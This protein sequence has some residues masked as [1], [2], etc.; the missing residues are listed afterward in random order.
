M[1][2][3]RTGRGPG[4]GAP[5]PRGTTGVL[6]ALSLPVSGGL[7][8]DGVTVLLLVLAALTAGW[9]DAVVGGAG[10]SSSRRCFSSR[11]QPRAGARDEQAREHHGDVG[12]RRDVLP[13][14][15]AGPAHGRAHGARRARGGRRGAALASRIPA[16]LF[17]PIILVVLVG[18][19]AYTIAKPS[20]GHSTNLRWE[21]NGHRW[22]AAGIGLVIGTYDG[23]LG[24]GTG[25]FFVIALVSILGTRSCRRRR[26]RRSRTSPRT[27]AR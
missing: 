5:R 19:A 17:K 9:I 4:P 7:E 12:E 3:S 20:L 6:P 26:S 25:T 18:V 16:D 14:R 13:A 21:G 11:H 15:R 24:P 23:L 2:G 8:I 22:A 27:P 10:S 1:D